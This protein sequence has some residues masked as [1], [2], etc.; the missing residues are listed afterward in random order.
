VAIHAHLAIRGIVVAIPPVGGAD[1]Y[2]NM[3][4]CHALIGV[5]VAEEWWSYERHSNDILAG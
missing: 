4:F 1:M 5:Y 3:P 2:L